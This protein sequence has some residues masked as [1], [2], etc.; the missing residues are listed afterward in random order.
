MD[1]CVGYAVRTVNAEKGTHSVPYLKP[2]CGIRN[3]KTKLSLIKVN[4]LPQTAWL[5]PNSD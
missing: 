2:E 1:H 3:N 4:L 5:I